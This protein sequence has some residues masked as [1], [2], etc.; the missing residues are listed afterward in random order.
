MVAGRSMVGLA[1]GGASLVVP[2]CVYDPNGRNDAD[3]NLGIFPSFRLRV[4]EEVW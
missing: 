3:R 1:I 2:L 4:F